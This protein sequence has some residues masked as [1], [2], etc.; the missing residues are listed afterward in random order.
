MDAYEQLAE[1]PVDDAVVP[2][3]PADDD[4]LPGRM[5]RVGHLVAVPAVIDTPAQVEQPAPPPEPQAGPAQ[6]PA[7][8]SLLMPAADVAPEPDQDFWRRGLAP[9]A[10]FTD[11][12]A[13][14]DQPIDY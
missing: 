11:V 5:G 14:P 6:A 12:R 9:L 13:L 10:D 1:E 4:L 8:P 7:P 2:W 3:D